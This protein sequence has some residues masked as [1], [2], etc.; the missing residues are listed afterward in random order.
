MFSCS[1][2]NITTAIKI[3]VD[4][5]G[6][7]CGRYGTDEMYIKIYGLKNRKKEN[8]YSPILQRNIFRDVFTKQIHSFCLSS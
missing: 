8:E 7:G 1:S 2:P 5:M 3:K 4:D 6:K